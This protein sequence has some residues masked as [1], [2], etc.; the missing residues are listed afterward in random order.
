LEDETMMKRKLFF[1]LGILV[2]C[3]P[4]ANAYRDKET[5]L[6]FTPFRNALGS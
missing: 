2:A 6:F 3:S 4:L 5:G 1:I